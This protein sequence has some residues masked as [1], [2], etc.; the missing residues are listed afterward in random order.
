VNVTDIRFAVD[1][2]T[3]IRCGLCAADCPVRVI[4]MGEA[5]WPVVP[6]ERETACIGCQHCLA[7]CPTAAL[8]ILGRRP[9]ESTPLAGNFPEPERLETLM[10]GR[11]SVRSYRD[12]DLEPALVRR[13]L[14]TAWHAPTG[15]NARQVRFTVVDDRR[16][17]AEIRQEVLAGLGRLAA[18]GLL[19]PEMAFFA[20]FVQLWERK[21]IDVIFRGAPHL[22]LASAPGGAGTPKED[23][24]IALTYFEL[25]AQSLGVGTVWNGFS[26][27][28]VG[29]L[30]PAVRRRLGIP[31]DHLLGGAISFGWPAIHYCRTVQHGPAI[32]HRAV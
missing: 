4:A 23:A 2:D 16:V 25:L 29:D 27:W 19:P 21:G 8:S 31:D 20:G 15:H 7:V 30:V 17:L 14:E 26:A 5:G 3:C 24:L 9:E 11:R 18:D 10:K 13:L 32:I 6:P 28:A 12:E 22:L 1:R